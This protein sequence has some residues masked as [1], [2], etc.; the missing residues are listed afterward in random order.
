MLSGCF[1]DGDS[2]SSSGNRLEPVNDEYNATVRRTTNGVPHIQADTLGSVAFG[3]GYAQASDNLC[4]LAETIVK[5]RSER[6]KYFGPGPND[7][8]IIS[9]FSLKAQDVYGGAKD[10]YEQLS[11][12]SRAMLDGYTAGYNQYLEETDPSDHSS[13]CQGQPW[14]MQIEPVDLLAHYRVIAQF[15]SGQ[16]FATGAVFG[17]TPPGESPSPSPVMASAEP[18]EK[19]QQMTSGVARNA[20]QGGSQALKE[21]PAM[22]SNA[23]AIGSDLSSA[24]GGALLGNP[25]FPYTGPRRLY[26]MQLTVPDYLNVQ[27]AG[28]LG[29]AI[30]LINYNE[31]L[32]WSHTVT[33]SNRFTVYEL[34]LKDGDPMT[35]IK[36][37][38][39]KS[40][41]SRTFQIEVNTGAPETQTLERTFYYS[42]YG[43]MVRLQEATEGGLSQWG[44]DGTAYTYRDANLNRNN[45]LDTWLRMSRASNLEEFKDVFRECGSTLWTNTIYA[46]A[47]GNAY[48]IDSSSVPNLSE[49]SQEVVNFKRQASADY[50]DLFNSGV[51][52]LDGDTSRDDW[53]E[54]ECNGI[55]PFEDRP[56]LQ[57]S[58]WVQ[59]S[60]DSHWATN[61]KSFLTGYSP[62]FGLEEVEQG[63]RTR[64]GIKMLQNPQSDGFGNGTQTKW[65]AGQDGKFSAQDLIDTIYNDRSFWAEQYL[66]ELRSRC[67]TI[68]AMAVNL[69]DGGSRAVD[70]GCDVLAN[71]DGYYDLDSVGAPV[72]RVFIANYLNVIEDNPGELTTAF[73]PSQPVA[74]PAGPDPANAGMADDRML[75]SLAQ[76]LNALDTAGVSY[77]AALRDVQVYQPS[78]G[79][80][81]GG[82]PRALGQSFPWHGGN[83][84]IDGTFN[85]VGVRDLPTKQDTLYPRVNP[86]TLPNTA[87]LAEQQGKWF[88][89]RGASY[90]FGLEFTED[91]P[92]AYGLTSYSQSTDPDSPFFNDQA[93][94]YSDKNPR[95]FPFS[96]SEIRQNLLDNGTTTISN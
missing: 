31:N 33:T 79:V 26:Q 36:D 70:E 8:N 83:G 15:A 18:T 6:A 43:P 56:K 4:T 60:N 41:T 24:S 47:E 34:T 65:P 40:I 20:V 35:Y 69:P 62:L 91:G 27:G 78:G 71:W 25:H 51:V 89:I 73:D 54:G 14:V 87:G 45:L 72:F 92:K 88:K 49:E 7:V 5:A 93:Q 52:L 2:G 74:T 3:A 38:E 42:E 23:W 81:P 19:V 77:N 16:G 21:K 17:A 76:G 75:Q 12:E 9:D 10:G 84:G 58:D 32:G 63:P 39:E 67:T 95:P 86:V 11:D 80:P 57:R 50:R 55:V 44:D 28:L 59:N 30:P 96:E 85:A 29:T 13:Q 90:H 94:R 66:S 68:G 46:D 82:S 37:G 53:V 48:Y 22:A 61:P 64:I 1:F